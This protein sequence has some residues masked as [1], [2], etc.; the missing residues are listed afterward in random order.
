[1]PIP[2]FQTIMLPFLTTLR[3]GQTHGIQDVIDQL[4]RQFNL[5]QEERYQRSPNS[6]NIVFNNK[7]G[8]T[9]THLKNAKLIE[10][11]N[12]GIVKISERGL[13]VLNE[14]LS[15]IDMR[16]LSRYPEYVQFR[17]AS[18]VSPIEDA[19][20]DT[21]EADISPLIINTL[22][23]IESLEHSYQEIRND[24]ADDLLEQI[25][26]C[27]PQFFEQMVIDLLISMGYGGSRQDAGQA[28]GQSHDGGVDGIIKEDKLGLDVIYVQAKRWNNATVGRPDVQNFVGSLVG[29]RAIKGIFITTS[30][31]S[32]EAQEYV[33]NIDKKVVLINGRELTQLMIDHGIGVTEISSYIIKRVDT[34]YF[35]EE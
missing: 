10:N 30:D 17:M 9:K 35:V 26:N 2:D 5:T 7:V 6:S 24:L 22:T 11:P 3:D 27:S 34:D 32:R 12:R 33:K 29:R 25:M 21:T 31:F 1:M 19:T 16:Y 13:E 28:I 20:V 23:P 4:A 8:W 15:R 14:N 18:R